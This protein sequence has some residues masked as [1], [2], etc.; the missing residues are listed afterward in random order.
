MAPRH[1]IKL[2][3]ENRP[4]G[5]TVGV[6]SLFVCA[7]IY[8]QGRPTAAP[9]WQRTSN[10]RRPAGDESKRTPVH[11]G[12][13]PTVVGSWSHLPRFASRNDVVRGGEAGDMAP[14]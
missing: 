1:G 11:A 9:V 5:E 12:A 2:S 13:Y 3:G 14:G 7:T 6:T 8:R 10:F 4:P